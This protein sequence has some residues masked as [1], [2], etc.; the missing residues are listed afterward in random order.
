MWSS[1][2]FVVSLSL[3]LAAQAG[4]HS[5]VSAGT[6]YGLG[7]ETTE[8]SNDRVR[9]GPT[10]KLNDDIPGLS[11][12]LSS[13]ELD[14]NSTSS[15]VFVLWT[16][17]TGSSPQGTRIV[18]QLLDASGQSSGSNI[19][20]TFNVPYPSIYKDYSPHVAYSASVDR[21]LLTSHFK[22]G[23]LEEGY[24]GR[25]LLPSGEQVGGN[26]PIVLEGGISA[27]Q[28][29][30]PTG[31]FIVFDVTPY[32]LPSIYTH[33]LDDS[34]NVMGPINQVF[35]SR[36]EESARSIVDV[37][38]APSLNRDLVLLST[39]SAETPIDGLYIDSSGSAIGKT[40][41]IANV[42]QE[43]HNWRRPIVHAEFDAKRERF[44]VAYDAVSQIRGRFINATGDSV[45]EEIVLVNSVPWRLY[46]MGSD[47]SLSYSPECDVYLLAT[48]RNSTEIF[49]QL[50][51]SNGS[52]IGS[53]VIASNSSGDVN[54]LE[55]EY[56]GEGR[57]YLA[58]LTPKVGVQT[59]Y[60]RVVNIV[61]EPSTALSSL[62]AVMGTMCLPR[63]QF[64]QAQKRFREPIPPRVGQ[65]GA[66]GRPCRNQVSQ[67]PHERAG[68]ELANCVVWRRRGCPEIPV[69]YA[70]P[71]GRV[72]K[73]ALES[74]RELRYNG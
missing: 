48:I 20:Y 40:F 45:G 31:N 43:E 62:I 58:W 70:P 9:I 28:Y 67:F 74:G 64:R 35:E 36:D 47:F 21:F 54:E 34:G 60:G 33:I 22:Y 8:T 59:A 55:T 50:L 24:Y 2:C 37:V 52:Q 3:L 18:G 17:P 49:L 39:V 11:P 13:L 51:D 12:S 26:F 6:A 38:S 46:N 29:N 57:F 66:F 56:V 23:S 53:S 63:R 44:L 71:V 30:E 19:T 7:L 10:I 72:A 4:Q 69:N 25:Q 61:P 5:I 14:V 68:A 65:T 16:H 15:E 32:P 42:I 27:T 1:S 41:E 73:S